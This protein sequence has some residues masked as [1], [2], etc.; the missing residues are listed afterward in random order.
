M[1]YSMKVI[2]AQGNPEPHYEKTRHNT[3]FMVLNTLVDQLNAKWVTKT[4]LQAHIAEVSI[5][6][7]KTLLVKPTTFYN[8]S[9]MSAR[10]VVDFYKLDAKDDLMVLH[11]DL[12]LPFGTV[13]VRKKGSDAGNNGIKSLNSHIGPDYTR[14]RIGIW[15]EKR[16]LVDDAD[17]VLS[18]FTSIESKKMRDDIIPYSIRLIEQFVAGNLTTTSHKI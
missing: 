18:K 7:T 6:G 10:A 2:F 16:D 11:D 3:G 13:R 15:S 12:A 5:E 8:D 9:G 14:M 17:F 4:K 1:V